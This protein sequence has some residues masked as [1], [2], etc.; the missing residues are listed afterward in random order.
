M[1]PV[2]ILSIPK[3]LHDHW[4]WG[5]G[6]LMSTRAVNPNAISFKLLFTCRWVIVRISYLILC[7]VVRNTENRLGVHN[8]L[9]P[10]YPIFGNLAGLRRVLTLIKF[11][12][13]Y[14]A[15]GS[16]WCAQLCRINFPEIW[17]QSN[18]IC[19]AKI[20]LL[21]LFAESVPKATISIRCAL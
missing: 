18:F 12:Q 10:Q 13:H 21:P 3:V 20:N 5:C 8:L 1:K 6:H 14:S 7:I 15:L 16:D 17:N 19:I 11:A 9:A 4:K 2:S